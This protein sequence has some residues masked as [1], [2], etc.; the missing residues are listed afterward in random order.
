ME[1]ATEQAVLLLGLASCSCSSKRRRFRCA[2]RILFSIVHFLLELLGFLF[3]DEAEAG[4][5]VLELKGVEKGSVLVVAPAVKDFLV[6]DDATGG[7]LPTLV[8][9][10]TSILTRERVPR[11]PPS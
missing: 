5:A 4:K 6:P 10:D 1:E 11:Y 9:N 3:V 8:N 7:R 2:A